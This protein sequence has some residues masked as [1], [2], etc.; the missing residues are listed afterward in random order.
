MSMR[1]FWLLTAIGLVVLVGAFGLTWNW[2]HLDN[3]VAEVG[4]RLLLLS[5]LRR[6]ALEQYFATA[7][8]EIKF[9]SINEEI[10]DLQ[11]EFIGEWRS[12][13]RL[14]GDPEAYLQQLYIYGNPFPWQEHQLTDAEDGSRFSAI[15]ASLHPLAKLFVL[16]R[17][18]YDFFLIGPE[19]DVFYT[20]AKERDF[21]TNLV[22]GDWRE[23]GLASAW[24]MAMDGAN[25]QPVVVTDMTPYGP[26]AGEPAIFMAR[27]LRDEWGENL[28]VIAFQLPTH[29]IVE[30][31][32]FTAGMGRTGETYLVGED[33]LMRSNSRFSRESTILRTTVNTATVASA[34]AGEQGVDFSDD[35]RGVEVLSAY[36]STRIGGTRW[37]VMAEI[38]RQEILELAAE[39]RPAIAPLMLFLYGI[40]LWSVWYARGGRGDEQANLVMGELS[41]QD[42]L[43]GSG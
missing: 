33:Y 5:N 10:L 20:V 4:N 23:S 25:H 12:F 15:H 26:S 37:A 36:S 6:G 1:R 27:A 42:E 38:D 14:E 17:G 11:R 39:D 31:M 24:R 34:L 40:S 2:V 19:G 13:A 30:I 8:A 35:Y 9:W 29:R 3:R 32:N 16:E 41:L 7:E 28:G 22:T 18:Y 43:S 21:A